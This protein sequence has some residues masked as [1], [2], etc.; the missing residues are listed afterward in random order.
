MK[1]IWKIVI[2]ISVLITI[3]SI[4]ECTLIPEYSPALSP[5]AME[6]SRRNYIDWDILQ[7]SDS[8]TRGQ[9]LFR[10]MRMNATDQDILYMT[11]SLQPVMRVYAA[12][13]ARDKKSLS[14]FDLLC[15]HLRD[16]AE[17]EVKTPDIHYRKKVGDFYM[18]FLYDHLSAEQKNHID[19]VIIYDK[20]NKLDSRL[21]VMERLSPNP[22]YYDRIREIYH[23]ESQSNTLVFLARFKMPQ[24]VKFIH[25]ELTRFYNPNINQALAAVGEYPA[26][27]FLPVLFDLYNLFI[28]DKLNENIDPELLFKAMMRYESI[29]VYALFKKSLWSADHQFINKYGMIYEDALTD[30]N[31]S[32]FHP[33]SHLIHERKSQLEL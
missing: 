9:T 7:P 16:I 12:S 1:N 19:S 13:L 22:K 29:K 32:F 14:H 15:A 18:S 28:Q 24:D 6:I 11:E 5:T 21:A 23:R 2:F 30:I 27:Q 8:L 3:V 20:M 10:T 25:Q 26:P 4:R 31:S 33:L 17:V